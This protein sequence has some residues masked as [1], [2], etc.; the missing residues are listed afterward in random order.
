MY[1]D[2]RQE[3][4]SYGDEDTPEHCEQWADGCSIIFEAYPDF[5]AADQLKELAD[6]FRRKAAELRAESYGA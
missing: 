2:R 4:S 6:D 3:T 1:E 5:F